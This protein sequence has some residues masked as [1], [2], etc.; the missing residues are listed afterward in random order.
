MT[1]VSVLGPWPDGDHHEAQATAIGALSDLPDGLTGMPPLV[2]PSDPGPWSGP[3]ARGVDLLTDMPAEVGP[4]GWKLADRPGRDLERV[5]AGAR[6]AMDVL[7]VAAYG[8]EGPL[9]L[10][11]PGPW[12]LASTLYLARGDRVLSDPGAV[13]DLVAALGEGLG[14]LMASVAGAVPGARPVVVLHE[15]RLGAVLDGAVLDF[16][17]HGRIWSVTGERAGAGLSSV[18]ATA[19]TAGAQGVVIHVGGQ[20]HA[21]AMG[22]AGAVGPDGLGVGAAQLGSAHWERLAGLVE[23]GVGLWLGLPSQDETAD[24]VAAARRIWGPW[25]AVGLPPAGLSTVVVHADL[26]RGGEVG[27]TPARPR[28]LAGV[29]ALIRDT[30]TVAVRLAERA[31]GS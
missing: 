1:G 12:T 18:V 31:A 25:T 16:S 11:V 22:V 20:A 3:L 26:A 6:Q 28:D 15:P 4:H 9:V 2:H 29:R 30:A 14:S 23:Q 27:R 5:R 24:S 10:A 7:A 19:R 8:Y 17:G 13:R 21:G